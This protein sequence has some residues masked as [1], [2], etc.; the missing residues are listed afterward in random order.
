[1]D[2][3]FLVAQNGSA[4]LTNLLDIPESIQTQTLEEVTR[5]SNRQHLLPPLR[6]LNTIIPQ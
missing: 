1:M 3:H 6:L 2:A 5:I 4:A